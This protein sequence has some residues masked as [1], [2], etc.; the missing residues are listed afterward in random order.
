MTRTIFLVTGIVLTALT[1]A[2]PSAFGMLQPVEGSV[3]RPD[4]GVAYFYA[5]ERATLASPVTSVY[6]D[7]HE[8][9]PAT[10]EQAID[11]RSDAGIKAHGSDPEAAVTFFY[12]NE[13]STL[14]S[15]GE[16]AAGDSRT[17][18]GTGIH[19]VFASDEPVSTTPPVGSGGETEWPQ[20]GVGLVIGIML[21][22]GLLL[23]MRATRTRPLAH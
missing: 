11:L 19:S 13:R 7:A 21:A 4:G 1:V 14:A 16:R 15:S 3:E 17:D 22:L 6:R 12:A 20:I 18:S 2:V 8:R 10:V 9:L 5:N 23:A